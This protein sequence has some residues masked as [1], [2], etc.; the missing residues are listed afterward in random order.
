V[1]SKAAKI[2]LNDKARRETEKGNISKRQK[3]NKI[4]LLTYVVF[5]LIYNYIVYHRGRIHKA[6]VVLNRRVDNMSGI[7][8]FFILFFSSSAESRDCGEYESAPKNYFGHQSGQAK[9]AAD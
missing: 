1:T 2:F 4:L 7:F 9:E 3:L 5:G 8:S 6:A